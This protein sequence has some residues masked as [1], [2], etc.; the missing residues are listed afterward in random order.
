MFDVLQATTTSPSALTPTTINFNSK[1]QRPAYSML[2]NKILT[3][4]RISAVEVK[5]FPG[6]ATVGYPSAAMKHTFTSVYLTEVSAQDTW[7][8]TVKLTFQKVRNF[9]GGCHCGISSQCRNIF[10][11][12]VL[13]QIKVE[14]CLTSVLV[15]GTS[16][17]ATCPSTIVTCFDMAARSVAC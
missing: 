9:C 17:S 10:F 7:N 8:I 15:A 13:V 5:S 3:G 11:H 14:P 16:A 4:S 2:M 1:N 12:V 6:T